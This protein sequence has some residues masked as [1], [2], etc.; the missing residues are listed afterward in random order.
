M[1]D[2]ILPLAERYGVNV[3]VGAGE[4]SITRC[5]ELVDRAAAAQRPVRILYVSDFD[6][7]GMSMPL[8]AAR[9]IEFILRK[10]MPDLDV[11]LRPIALTHEQ[12]RHYRLPRTP[13]KE[14]ESRADKFEARFGEGATELDALEALH[15]G[16]LAQIL[17][18]EILRYYDNTL[19]DQIAE[20][21]GEGREE[22]D[23]INAEVHERHAAAIQD[24]SDEHERVMA[25]IAAYRAK[26][27]PI[28]EAIESDFGTRRH[29]RPSP[30]RPILQPP[31]TQTRYST[32]RATMSSK[33]TGTR[34]TATSL[35]SAHRI[36]GS[37]ST[38]AA[39]RNS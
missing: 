6:P 33:S 23:R 11:Q 35:S 19:T 5:L 14:S 38:R 20:V 25:A 32:R 3:L 16:E 37:A 21:E 1:N 39:R 30:M 8:A 22:L 28:I 9:K 31:K 10:E 13:I 27:G 36:S 24:L 29:L 12:C 18:R 15:P 7:G 4:T 26:A 17:E 34:S 2:I